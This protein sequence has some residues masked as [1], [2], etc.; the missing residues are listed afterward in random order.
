M[1]IGM[2]LDREFPPDDRVEKEAR[3]LINAGHQVYLLCFRFG[4]EATQESYRNI[5]VQRVYMPKFLFKK[6]SPLILTFPFYHW[7]WKVKIRRFILGNGL[8]ALH[9][10]DLPLVGTALSIRSEI[11]IPIIAD[12]HEN[13]PVFIEISRHTNT[14]LGRLLVN[15]K[16]WYKVERDWLEKADYI[17]CVADEM[18]NRLAG[19]LKG[20]KEMVVTPNTIDEDGFLQ[21]Q[22]SAPQIENKF[23][24]KFCILFFGRF[25]TARG[26]DVLLQAAALIRDRIPNLKLILVGDGSMLPGLKQLARDLSLSE[27]VSFEGWQKSA[28][29]AAYMKNA[30]I[31]VIPHV[32]SLQ[33]DNSSPNKLFQ[34]MLFGKPII[35]SNC[36]SIERI[37]REND[38]GLIF[39]SG[40]SQA[41][42]DCIMELYHD[43]DKCS[44]LGENARQAV[45][46]KYTWSQTVKPQLEMY[47]RLE[48]EIISA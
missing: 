17:I 1:K 7:Y 23:Q 26:L 41:L 20:K 10:H 21:M 2:V 24:D 13:Y 5:N 36:N 37:L 44:R 8:Q 39:E 38:S 32:K 15:K 42:A 16:K 4:K 9:I 46:T 6:L 48:Q 34:F 31:A 27:I 45:M 47:Q 30:Q 33:T 35:S 12:L 14:R 40:N 29:L 43:P 28:L 25:D 19:F 18:R 11:A 3:S 22:I